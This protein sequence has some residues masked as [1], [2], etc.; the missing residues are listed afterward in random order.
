MK[1]VSFLR[2]LA[3]IQLRFF[4]SNAEQ[5]GVLC[6]VPIV[7]EIVQLFVHARMLRQHQ[8]EVQRTIGPQPSSPRRPSRNS[9]C[10]DQ[11][12]NSKFRTT[13]GNS[14]ISGTSGRPRCSIPIHSEGWHL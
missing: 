14:A 10:L 9:L 4:V 3:D 7:V 5:P 12:S 13:G 2:A 11:A 6:E 1:N 8:D